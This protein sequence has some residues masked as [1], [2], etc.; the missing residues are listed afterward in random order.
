MVFY[1]AALILAGGVVLAIGFARRPDT[2]VGVA[3]TET[4]AEG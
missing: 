3:E 2:R 1:V 4:T